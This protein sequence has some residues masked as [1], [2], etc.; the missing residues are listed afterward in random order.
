MS[1]GIK[2]SKLISLIATFAGAISGIITIYFLNL[3]FDY[4]DSALIYTYLAMLSSG[5]A[6]SIYKILAKKYLPPS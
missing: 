3:I 4:T 2:N 5:A 1:N 6:V